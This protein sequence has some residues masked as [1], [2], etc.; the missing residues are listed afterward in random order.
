MVLGI[1]FMFEVIDLLRRVADRPDIG[2]GFV[3]K[4]VMMKLPRT[5]DMIFPFV[6]MIAAM[7]TFQKVSKGVCLGLSGSGSVCRFYDWRD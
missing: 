5:L 4:M 3:L 1:I 2:W 7:V 6:M